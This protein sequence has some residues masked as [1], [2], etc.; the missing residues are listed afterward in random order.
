[1]VVPSV[2]VENNSIIIVEL[3]CDDDD[4]NNS[5]FFLLG[6]AIFIHDG[7][8]EECAPAPIFVVGVKNALTEDARITI[9]NSSN[10]VIIR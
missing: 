6:D 2:T 9:V 8:K 4:D 7:G 10:F 5:A 3:R 1:V